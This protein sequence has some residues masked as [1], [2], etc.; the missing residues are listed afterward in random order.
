MRITHGHLQG[1]MAQPHLNA[2][3]ID[4]APDQTG[5]TGMT[6]NMRNDLIVGAESNFHLCFIP[7]LAEPD[8]IEHREG[9]FELLMRDMCCF[10]C[11]PGEGDSATTIRLGEPECNPLILHIVPGDA[12]C[13]TETATRVD[14][15]QGKPVAIFATRF[16]RGEQALLFLIFK[17]SNAT[18]S[19]FLPDEL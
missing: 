3:D 10:S 7:D 4:P 5:G 2:T 12:D 18:D 14:K 15:E 19:L 16:D 13:F 9:T 8:L 11:T 1:L 17:E 6:Q